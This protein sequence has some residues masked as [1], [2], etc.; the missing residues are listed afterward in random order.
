MGG[1]KI[2]WSR[3]LLLAGLLLF[4]PVRAEASDRNG[5]EGR[6]SF[7]VIADT[8]WTEADDGRNPGTCAVDIINQVTL[9]FIQHGVKLVVAVGD[10]T[11][12]AGPAAMD[13]RAVYA[14]ALYNAGIGFF[15]LRGNH[16]SPD[17]SE[18]RRVFPQTQGGLQNSTPPDAFAVANP[19][20]AAVPP[21]PVRGPP[22]TVGSGF[23]SPPAMKG[24]SYSFDY[25]NVRFVLLDQ[26]DGRT[27]TIQPQQPWISRVLAAR[28][29]GFHAIVFGHKGLR[30]EYHPD[31]LFGAK[32]GAD[33]AAADAF[34]ASLAGSGVRYYVGGHDHMHD[35][36]LVVASDGSGTRVTQL[37]C[38]SD[39]SK[40]YG[41]ARSPW[42]RLVPAFLADAFAPQRRVALAQELWRVG[43]YVFTVEGPRVT[44]DYYSAP[45]DLK[46]V[47][48]D[49]V[50]ETTPSLVFSKRE[51]FGYDLRGKEFVVAHGSSLAVVDDSYRGTRARILDGLNASGGKD[52]L[53]RPFAHA[54]NTGWSP[55]P[56]GSA[57]DVLHLSGMA[58]SL[59]SERTDPYVLS[60]SFDADRGGYR[61]ASPG[62][63]G[64]EA[65]DGEGRWRNAA[66]LDE[67]GRKTFVE[68]PWRP[69]LGPGA[70]GVD[71][72]TRT[73]WA[74]LDFDGDFRV[75][76]FEERA[77]TRLCDG[78]GPRA[79]ENGAGGR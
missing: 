70:H 45:V 35:R 25:Q 19:D 66:D 68:G 5:G 46:L 64:V 40:F 47:R 1:A 34:I 21:P 69:G 74:V 79:G 32:R 41:A 76:A 31:N 67:G 27:D 12:A 52:G 7:G 10:L 33:P 28:P 26:F 30:T 11:D 13:I 78:E 15:P 43:Y 44:V 63:F 62:T 22:F 54:V 39:S 18:F 61:S 38:A 65:K 53:G 23:D 51:T 2:V 57:S 29:P 73:A 16:D 71:P 72:G 48:G 75:G 59:G 50:I 4:G 17:P 60:L 36:S 8:Q 6:W 77:V 56:C 3:V 49:H 55:R 42:R 14:Q 58:N 9:R 24:L 37:V 20:A